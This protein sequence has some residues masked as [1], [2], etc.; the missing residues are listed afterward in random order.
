MM[1]SMMNLPVDMFRHEFLPY[2]TLDDIVRLDEA[3]MS[4]EYRP[5]LLDTISG[6]ILMGFKFRNET[7]FLSSYGNM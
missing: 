7:N 5:K 6:V 4:H 3:C 2:L 1:D